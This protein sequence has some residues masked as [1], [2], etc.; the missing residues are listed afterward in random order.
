MDTPEVIIE[1]R[2]GMPEV[3]SKS[4]GVRLI[5]RDFDVGWNHTIEYQPEDTVTTGGV[6][7]GR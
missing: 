2:G 6:S 4:P 1:I 7:S 3:V 5:I